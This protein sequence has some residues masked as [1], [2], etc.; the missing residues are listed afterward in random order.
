MSSEEREQGCLVVTLPLGFIRKHLDQIIRLLVLLSISNSQ[1]RKAELERPMVIVF[2]TQRIKSEEER[3][4]PEY[5]KKY[6]NSSYR[7]FNLTIL[8]FPV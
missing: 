1:G 8:Y 2:D 3:S 5:S 4:L 7:E 6:R